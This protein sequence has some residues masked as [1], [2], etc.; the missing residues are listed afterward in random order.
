MDAFAVIACGDG[1]IARWERVDADPRD[2]AGQSKGG[3]SVDGDGGCVVVEGDGSGGGNAVGAGD[4]GGEDFGFP[5]NDRRSAVGNGGGGSGGERGEGDIGAAASADIA[6]LIFLRADDDIG[7]FGEI[8][9]GANDGGSGIVCDEC[10]DIAGGGG[11]SEGG[12]GEGGVAQVD[13]AG[14]DGELAAGAGPADK[15]RNGISAVGLEV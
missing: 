10:D 1:V 3:G 6:D 13:G 2:A 9:E 7:A 15:E 12:G 14:I 4:S 5:F 11:I 8:I